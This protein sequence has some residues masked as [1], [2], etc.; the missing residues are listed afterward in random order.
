MQSSTLL[1]NGSFTFNLAVFSTA[2]LSLCIV[3]DS[4]F[5]FLPFIGAPKI[6][7]GLPVATGMAALAV[8]ESMGYTELTGFA[9]LASAVMCMQSIGALSSQKTARFGSVLG[10]G[11]VTLG[12]AAT[13]GLMYNAGASP[14]VFAQMAGLL[15]VGGLAGFL[16]AGKVCVLYDVPVCVRTCVCVCVPGI[17]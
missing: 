16:V 3:F 4:V 2:S 9:G 13:V 15:G 14:E 10:V 5:F 1:P 6:A 7:V 17:C 11:G 12:L 8:G